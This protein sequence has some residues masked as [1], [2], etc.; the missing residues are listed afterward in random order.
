MSDNKN[1]EPKFNENQAYEELRMIIAYA[2]ETQNFATLE[3]NIAI[4]EKKYPLT[5]FIDQE[6]V[7]KIKAILNK[8]YLSRLI[9]D[10]LAAKVL[11]EQERTKIAYENLQKIIDSVKKSKDYKTAQKAITSWKA[12]LLDS[13]LSLHSFNKVDFKK[14]CTMLLFPSKELAKQKEASQSLRELV[15]TS[16]ELDSTTLSRRITEWQSKHTLE[17][18]PLEL[19]N[20]ITSITSTVFES[21][22]T[23]ENEEKALKEIQEYVS[24]RNIEASVETIS[25]ILA[26]YNYDRFDDKFK[27][28]ISEL[29]S[30]AMSVEQVLPKTVEDTD[31]QDTK[32]MSQFYIPP[33]QQA[34]I[35]ELKTIFSK[36]PHNFDGL[37]TWIYL[38]RKLNFS[39]SARD[40]IKSQFSMAGFKKP[41]GG[42]YTIPTLNADT[43]KLTNSNI[44]KIRES[45][46]LNYLGILYTANY[47]L[48]SAEKESISTIH[49]KSKEKL[50]SNAIIGNSTQSEIVLPVIDNTE[51]GDDTKLD[52]NTSSTAQDITPYSLGT[53]L[54]NES[55]IQITVE[56]NLVKELPPMDVEIDDKMVEKAISTDNAEVEDAITDRTL[57]TSNT[58]VDDSTQEINLVIEDIL[59]NPLKSYKLSSKPTNTK[60]ENF[61]LQYNNSEAQGSSQTAKFKEE[62]NEDNLDRSVPI[63]F[64]STDTLIVEQD[65]NQGDDIELEYKMEISPKQVP[66]KEITISTDINQ[67]DKAGSN[68]SSTFDTE[69]YISPSESS[70][71]ATST[72]SSENA[73]TL[74]TP[75]DQENVEEINYA[76]TSY[77]IEQL[78]IHQTELEETLSIQEKNNG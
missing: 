67:P 15:D 34:A 38:H 74:L 68:L 69:T 17:D 1:N 57:S 13:G 58:N 64:P 19:K 55:T 50:Y 24:S 73:P 5:D 11:K 52:I 56:D 60:S 18:F 20:E 26:K 53:S 42:E 71:S 44:A 77:Y 4:W 43:K 62:I 66:K 48:S 28:Q 41:T 72:S 10:Y 45:V 36:N 27:T 2:I 23:K 12:S 32:P 30:K 16:S 25:A 76:I 63:E 37:F 6:I 39:P 33:V 65:S 40:E 75:E 51:P 3:Q 49:H 59:K 7:R 9:G 29:T 22:S 31:K 35:N 8:D 14:I 70:Y 21:I 46:V 61:E 54:Q 47:S 78:P